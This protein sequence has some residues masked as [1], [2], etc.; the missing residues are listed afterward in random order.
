MAKTRM[1]NT[2]FWADGYI[3][4]LEP[5]EKLLFLY[6]LTNQ[7]T[8]ICG[9]Y[10]LPL[11]TIT[12]DTGIEQEKVR[13]IISRFTLDGK[14]EYLDGWVIIKNFLKHQ[15]QGSPRV[16]KG[17]ELALAEVPEQIRNRVS[18]G[19][20]TQPHSNSNL[21]SNSN[22]KEKP[23][24]SLDYL[25]SIPDEDL[26][27]LS[28][29]YEASKAQIK[30]KAE[31]MKNYCL[32]KGKSYRNYRAFL[33]NGLDKDFGRRVPDKKPEIEQRRPLT[34][35]EIAARD[36]IAAEIRALGKGM[37]VPD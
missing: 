31:T 22:S 35:E 12:F 16:M 21:N 32:S 6:F 19:F 36:R 17:V 33:E 8:N 9:I 26:T 3:A 1:V 30:R 15:Q 27:I 29:K 34:P 5:I 13:N 14:I 18:I 20:D 11:R 2:R 23:H 10:E 4:E 7:H 25:T 37:K 24:A 28:E